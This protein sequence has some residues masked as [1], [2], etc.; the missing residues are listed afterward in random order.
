MCKEGGGGGLLSFQ[1]KLGT[2]DTDFP[3]KMTFFT[4]LTLLFRLFLPKIG[5][6]HPHKNYIFEMSNNRAIC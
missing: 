4:V 2:T 5:L 6:S 3:G 1:G